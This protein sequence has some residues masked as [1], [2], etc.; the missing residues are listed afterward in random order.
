MKG[1]ESS[2]AVTLVWGRC[3]NRTPLLS[4]SG[5]SPQHGLHCSEGA[6]AAPS[7]RGSEE[8]GKHNGSRPWMGVPPS[9]VDWG[10]I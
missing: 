1:G 5:D 9:E 6:V 3:W 7:A 2:R 10:E 8:T 4:S